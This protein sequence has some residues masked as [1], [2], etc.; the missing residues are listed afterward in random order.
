MTV[1]GLS[2]EDVYRR[3][4][5]ALQNAACSAVGLQTRVRR[6]DTEFRSLLVEAEVRRGWSPDQVVA[7]RDARLREFLIEASSNRFMAP[8]R[9]SQ[10]SPFAWSIQGERCR[11]LSGRSPLVPRARWRANGR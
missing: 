6:Y 5:I 10:C 8:R 3:L 9:S 11:G 4:P 7:F 1:A 2:A